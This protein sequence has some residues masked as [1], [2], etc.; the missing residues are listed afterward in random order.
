MALTREATEAMETAVAET[1]PVWCPTEVAPF[2]MA[3]GLTE[4]LTGPPRLRLGKIRTYQ[5]GAT[6]N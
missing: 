5:M 3:S 2:L 6:W 4:V 1:W